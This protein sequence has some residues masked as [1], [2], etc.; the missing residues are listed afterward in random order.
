[1]ESALV[2]FK[3]RGEKGNLS[4]AP[5][6]GKG[7]NGR[8]EMNAMAAYLFDFD[9]TLVDSMPAYSAIM[10]GI[11]AENKLAYPP[12]VIKRITPLGYVGTAK[13]FIE[14]GAPQPLEAMIDLINGRMLHAYAYEI[15]AKAGVK[16]ALEAMKQRG[17]S[18]HVLT[19]SPHAVLDPCL[20][21]LGL[22]ELFEN[23]WSCEDFQ[24]TKSDPEIYRMAAQ[25]MGKGVEE[26]TFLDDNLNADR[27][28]KQAGMRVIGV[29]DDSSKDMEGAIRA[30]TDGY[31]YDLRDVLSEGL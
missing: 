11:L 28:A 21:R 26:V 23:V 18:L 14:L 30:A 19:A 10:L 6:R 1:M 25:R 31:V 22:W 17:D 15:P 24:T 29:Y 5:R 4:V 7:Y 16:E 13:Y 3:S 8:Q 12:D 9:G 20:K 27:T 2:G